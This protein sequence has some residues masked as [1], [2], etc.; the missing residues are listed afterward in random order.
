MMVK[1]T[2]RMRTLIASVG[3]AALLFGCSAE[4][5]G[6]AATDP[7]PA[8][9]EAIAAIVGTVEAGSELGTFLVDGDGHS[10]YLFTSDSPGVSSCT[11]ECLA[12]WPPLLTE[13][14]PVAE[15]A[16]QQA[17][18]STFTRD[19]GTVQVAYAGWPLYRYAADA[20]AGDVNGQGVG[21][22]WF[23][24][25]PDGVLVRAPGTEVRDDVYGG[26]TDSRSG[27]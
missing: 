15:G 8:A 17:L 5:T 25:G 12:A 16:V 3:V 4:S 6:S 22:V 24:V 9:V 23:V 20:V 14:E 1:R 18:L 19:D 26:A 13:G 7:A 21:D 11:G 27:Y 2:Q 10:L